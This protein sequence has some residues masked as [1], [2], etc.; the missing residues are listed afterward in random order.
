MNTSSLLFSSQQF[1]FLRLVVP[2]FLHTLCAM[3]A[4]ALSSLLDGAFPHVSSILLTAMTRSSM[5]SLERRTWSR[6]SECAH[7]TVDSRWGI[8]STP[9]SC[10]GQECTAAVSVPMKDIPRRQWLRILPIL[11]PQ[12]VMHTYLCPTYISSSDPWPVF[13]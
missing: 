9:L 7:Q 8:P 3:C 12:R 13:P 10:S 5:F 1:R 11:E 2:L 4:S 6:I